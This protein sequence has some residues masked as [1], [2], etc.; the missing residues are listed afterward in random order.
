METRRRT[1][2]DK[3]KKTGVDMDA[4]DEAVDVLF[5]RADELDLPRQ[6]FARADEPG[7]PGFLDVAPGRLG[8]TL[9]KAIGRVL[10]RDGA[11]E[12]EQNLSRH[13]FNL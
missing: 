10:D 13:P 1:G 8:E 11:I 4:G 5:A 3:G 6:A 9:E 12:I 2:L 7:F